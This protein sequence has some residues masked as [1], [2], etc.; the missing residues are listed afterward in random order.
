[1]IPPRSLTRSAGWAVLAVWLG[2]TMPGA[3]FAAESA[4][5]DDPV[6]ARVGEWAIH[7]SDLERL[8]E[9]LPVDA[10]TLAQQDSSRYLSTAIREEVLFQWT[11]GGKFK[12]DRELRDRLKAIVYQH[13]LETQVRSRVRVTNPEIRKY[14]EDNLDL[15]RGGHV[16]ARRIY[17]PKANQC[18]PLR[19][20]IDSESSFIEAA[21]RL[22]QDRGTA[23]T[24]GDLGYL[25]PTDGPL[26]FERKLFAMRPGE[27]RV[28]KGAKGCDLVRLVEKTD[29]PI[30]PLAEVRESLRAYL[31]SQQE[32]RFLEELVT[33]ARKTVK[34]KL[35]L[36]RPGAPATSNRKGGKS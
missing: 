19:Q 30:P 10:G 11:I 25:L 34:V 16:R 28:F 2:L 6:V 17:L 35:Y 5:Q 9:S 14:Y 21:V 1:M 3:A 12:G 27:M 26:G 24:G 32:E 8:S 33:E 15:V 36:K 7:A 18:D 4:P 29:P 13:V 22:S 20:E 23:A 31:E